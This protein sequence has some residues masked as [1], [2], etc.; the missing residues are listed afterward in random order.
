MRFYSVVTGIASLVVI[1]STLASAGK[2][3][4]DPNTCSERHLAF[5]RPQLL[6][7]T[8]IAKR[9]DYYMKEDGSTPRFPSMLLGSQAGLAASV[10]GG[11][12]I[13]QGDQQ[14]RITGIASYTGETTW[15]DAQSGGNLVQTLGDEAK[16]ASASLSHLLTNFE[17]HILQCGP[18][19]ESRRVRIRLCI[20]STY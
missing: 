5:L 3:A 7:A 2:W 6:R 20:Q 19:G 17:G 18:P 15:S 4:F 1:L 13:P 14:M 16:T 8:T 12:W 10:F 9:T 11:G